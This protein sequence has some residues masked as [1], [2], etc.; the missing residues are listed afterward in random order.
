MDKYK[1]RQV[2]GSV[3][4]RSHSC[5][6]TFGVPLK[7]LLARENRNTSIPRFVEDCVTFL[8]ASGIMIL[9]VVDLFISSGYRGIVSYYRQF[10]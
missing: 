9:Y 10:E 3:A 2:R 1:K 8:S 5:K 6:P 7:E 4:V